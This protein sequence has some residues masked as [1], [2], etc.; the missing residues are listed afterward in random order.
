MVTRLRAVTGRQPKVALVERGSS[1]APGL[2]PRARGYIEQ[3]LT[4]LGIVVRAGRTVTAIRGDGVSLD[5]GERISAAT[6]IWTGG[7][8]ATDLTSMLQV[9]RDDSGRLPVDAF[10]RVRGIT[11]VYAAGDVARALADGTRVAPMS[12]KYAIPM[13]ETAGLNAA[14]DLSGAT[15][16]PFAPAPYVTCLDLGEAGG[17]FT[18]GWDRDIKLTGYWAATMKRTI[19]RE[20]IYPPVGAFGSRPTARPAA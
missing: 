7:F 4:T 19:N 9:E 15:M 5:G 1:V 16:Q 13:G 3:A 8:R 12:C 2:N 18:Q 11:A 10:L 17:L 6:T 20:P 14:A